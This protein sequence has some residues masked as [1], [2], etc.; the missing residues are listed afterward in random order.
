MRKI[1]KESL[2]WAQTDA[3]VPLYASQH[4]APS[5][6]YK[7][8]KMSKVKLIIPGVLTSAAYY[9]ARDGGTVLHCICDEKK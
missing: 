8:R 9:E 1:M 5:N 7:C 2:C 4:N 6:A 3:L